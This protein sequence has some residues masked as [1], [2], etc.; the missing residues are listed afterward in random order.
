V[1]GR[2]G[3]GKATAQKGDNGV[4]KGAFSQY[5]RVR[6]A[7]ERADAGRVVFSRE[8]KTKTNIGQTTSLNKPRTSGKSAAK[9]SE[10]PP[11]KTTSWTTESCRTTKPEKAYKGELNRN[12]DSVGG[13]TRIAKQRQK[14]SSTF[15]KKRQVHGTEVQLDDRS[16]SQRV[17]RRARPRT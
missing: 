9:L 4:V 3:G 10:I 17:K 14:S 1:G 11:S 6:K 5:E 13:A 2:R 12:S 7:G 8:E 16:A 15:G